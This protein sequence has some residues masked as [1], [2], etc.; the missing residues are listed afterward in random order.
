MTVLLALALLAA[1]QTFADCDQPARR[2]ADEIAG[3]LDG[4][5]ATADGA[6]NRVYRQALAGLAPADR[7]ALR[8]AQRA[9][10]A[11]RIKDRASLTG[12]WRARRDTRVRIEAARADVTAIVART[13]QLQ[14]YLVARVP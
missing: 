10:L 7:A 14:A 6:L 5:R 1:P 2:T 11:F 8:D 9:W 4:L 13:R 12:P 3:C